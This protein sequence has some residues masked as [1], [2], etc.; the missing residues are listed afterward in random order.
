LSR[1]IEGA[2]R[3]KLDDNAHIAPLEDIALVKAK[4]REELHLF[5]SEI[6][7]P[8]I[9]LLIDD[10]FT[11]QCL[12]SLLQSLLGLDS[13]QGA[14]FRRYVRVV[15]MDYSKKPKKYKPDISPF[16]NHSLYIL[17]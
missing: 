2:D 8:P 1:K 17:G 15:H 12:V 3:S 9:V 7:H 5:E 10:C 13:T 16:K 4:L 14:I 6:H 11:N